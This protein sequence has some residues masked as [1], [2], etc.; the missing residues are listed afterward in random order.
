MDFKPSIF[1]TFVARLSQ[2]TAL[3][4]S[5]VTVI[6]TALHYWKDSLGEVERKLCSPLF[7]LSAEGSIPNW[8]ATILWILVALT[9][10]CCYFLQRYKHKTIE[11]YWLV[12]AA[13]FTYASIDECS[14]IHEQTVPFWNY[15][16]SHGVGLPDW[17][18]EPNMLWQTLYAPPAL[19]FFI[20]TA[21][22]L[23]R[24]SVNLPQIRFAFTGAVACFFLAVF[25]ECIA[26]SPYWAGQFY[27][28]PFFAQSRIIYNGEEV[29]E[30]FGTIL[31]L[32]S[33]MTYGCFLA[34]KEQVPT[35]VE[36]RISENT[37][38]D[39]APHVVAR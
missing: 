3:L 31:F 9:A 33:F 17:A 38:K 4:L 30:N 26:D 24:K 32:Y 34:Q 13:V 19:I 12:I 25:C 7:S 22:F 14:Q 28:I 6:L 2:R 37:V 39:V 18:G 8:F 15:F 1:E 27:K 35:E 36:T 20:V 29:L 5:G 23:W 16:R 11:Q 21:I 10:L